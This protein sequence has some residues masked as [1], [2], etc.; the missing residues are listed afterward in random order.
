MARIGRKKSICSHYQVSRC[1][2][3]ADHYFYIV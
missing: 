3:G 2:S 1:Y